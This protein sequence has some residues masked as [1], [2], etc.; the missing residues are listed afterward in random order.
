M[1]YKLVFDINE[2]DLNQLFGILEKN[3]YDFCFAD[4]CL[5]LYQKNNHSASISYIMREANNNNYFLQKISK[6]PDFEDPKTFANVWLME[7]WDQDEL[8]TLEKKE[9]ASLRKMMKNINEATEAV[10]NMIDK[11]KN[12]GD[13]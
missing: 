2:V 11:I 1:I 3:N 9:Q 4:D 7:K 5:Y 13:E 12:K 6:R 10:K 8:R